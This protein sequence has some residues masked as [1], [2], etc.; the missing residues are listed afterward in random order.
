MCDH[1]DLEFF[2]E[3]DPGIVPGTSWTDA[4]AS[5]LHWT[6]PFILVLAFVKSATA[7]VNNTADF[8]QDILKG[9]ANYAGQRRKQI[10]A[11]V[12]DIERIT[13][14]AP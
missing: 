5:R 10:E 4:G 13:E 14:G 7:A 11:A 8:A 6:D 12:L 1:G 9:H 2:E 3:G